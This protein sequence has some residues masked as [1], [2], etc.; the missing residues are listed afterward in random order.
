V[1]FA[2]IVTVPCAGC[3]TETTVSVRPASSVAV[4]GPALSFASTF[5]V[6]AV[7]SFVVAVSSR[8]TG[9]SLTAVTVTVNV[10]AAL[11]SAPPPLSIRRTVTVAVPLAS[12]AVV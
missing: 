6:T 1:L 9:A 5:T 12:G 8:A 10:W 7:S 11:V 4:A 2:L 3:V